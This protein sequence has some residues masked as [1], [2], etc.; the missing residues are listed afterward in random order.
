MRVLSSE[1]QLP[2]KESSLETR[3]RRFANPGDDSVAHTFPDYHPAGCASL[4]KYPYIC[5]NL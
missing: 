4:H 2:F 3:F 5:L 1:S